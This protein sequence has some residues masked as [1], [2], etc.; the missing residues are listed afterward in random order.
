MTE[1]D[2]EALRE[3]EQLMQ[4][5]EQA[6]SDALGEGRD[7]LRQNCAGCGKEM[8]IGSGDRLFAGRWYHAQCWEL[9]RGVALIEAEASSIKA[10][11][12]G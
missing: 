5:R 1:E 10:A 4:E 2:K 12:T 9:T 3:I 6:L 7:Y 8:L 11:D